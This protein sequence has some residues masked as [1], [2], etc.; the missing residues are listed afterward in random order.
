MSRRLLCLSIFMP[1]LAGCA[2][3]QSVQPVARLSA[4]EVCIIENLAVRPGFLDVYKRVLGEKGYAVRQLPPG[5]HFEDC[6]VTSTYT[7]N[8]RWDL[9]L[10]MAFADIRVFHKGEQTGQ[11]VYDAL[12]GSANMGKFIKGEEKIAELVNQL[13]PGRFVAATP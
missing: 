10:Y 1:L 9:A 11:A 12:G 6:P 8:W 7:A 5:A 4:N 2:I 13:F 3:K